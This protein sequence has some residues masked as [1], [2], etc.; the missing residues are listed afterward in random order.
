MKA[1]QNFVERVK[2]FILASGFYNYYLDAHRHTD[3]IVWIYPQS[4]SSPNVIMLEFDWSNHTYK[5]CVGRNG[6][7]TNFH[8]TNEG[9]SFN[10]QYFRTFDGF[11]EWLQ[12]KVAD[13]WH[14]FGY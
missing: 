12:L 11:T 1:P 5:V 6:D 4:G 13:W 2:G 3:N 10:P 14:Y 7:G 8:T 9:N